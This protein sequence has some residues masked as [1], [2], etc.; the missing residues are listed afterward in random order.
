[1]TA[2]SI[3]PASVADTDAIAALHAATWRSA[4]RGIFK[5]DTLG[6]SLDGAEGQG[7]I[8][9]WATGDAGFGASIDNLHVRSDRRS[10]GL[11]RRLLG[12]AMQRVAA[13]GERRA[14]LW[15][16]D[17]NTRAIDFYR[18]LGGEIVE[19]GLDEVDGQPVPHSRIAWQDTA[20]LVQACS[21]GS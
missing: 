2:P 20:E 13:R 21:S 5:D 8:A 17:A 15:V 3:R 14:Y 9:V 18:R 7:F 1:V 16:F 4:Y 12:A 10:A 11:G 6:P 19:Q